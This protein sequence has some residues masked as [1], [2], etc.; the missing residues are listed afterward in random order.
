LAT[1]PRIVFSDEVYRLGIWHNVAVTDVAGNVDLVHMK[2]LGRSYRELAAGYPRGIVTCAVIRAGVP[3]AAADARDESA[4]FITE[5]GDSV[6][7]MGMI[8][9][10][11]GVMAQVLRTVIR[12]INVVT[13][14][15]K[16][17]LFDSVDDV[18]RALA[19]LVAHPQPN[20]DVRAELSAA[21]A[22]LRKDYLP[23]PA[24]QAA[25]R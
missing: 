16:L 6:L 23:Q 12:G 1:P 10:E 3:V 22:A 14:N 8:I 7:R 19:P 18:A 21:I 4:R 5:L 17:V 2:R 13:R 24:P 11:K 15:T 9:E 25:R 20:A